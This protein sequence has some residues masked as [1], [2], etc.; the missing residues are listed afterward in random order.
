MTKKI[1]IKAQ[2]P[3]GA[4]E[5]NRSFVFKRISTHNTFISTDKP[6]YRPGELGKLGLY[7]R[8]LLKS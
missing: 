3:Q 2:L 1:R 4:F 7:D 5:D 8:F 6:I